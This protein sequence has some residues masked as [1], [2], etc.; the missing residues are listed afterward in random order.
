MPVLW[1]TIVLLRNYKINIL[2]RHSHIFKQ[3]P[4]D[5]FSSWFPELPFII[6]RMQEPPW[7]CIQGSRRPA[8][9]K[10]RSSF[11]FFL[12]SQDISTG[13][14]CWKRT[15][16]RLTWLGSRKMGGKVNQSF[17]KKE[18]DTLDA[19]NASPWGWM[20]SRSQTSLFLQDERSVWE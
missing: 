3:N 10:Q 19:V 6:H 8:S 13:W 11:F 7:G 9:V 14:K 20:Q 4:S 18:L 1:H 15:T 5:S 12:S 16:G 17:I 2:W